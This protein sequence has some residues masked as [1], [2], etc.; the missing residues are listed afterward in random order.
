MLRVG[1]SALELFQQVK[2]RFLLFHSVFLLLHNTIN[3]LLLPSVLLTHATH[4][5]GSIFHL[6]SGPSIATRSCHD[7]MLQV[8]RVSRGTTTDHN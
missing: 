8:P 1:I 7:A 2:T 6:T 5:S 4:A 3:L